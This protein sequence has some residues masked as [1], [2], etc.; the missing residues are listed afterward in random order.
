M[1]HLTDIYEEHKDHRDQFEVIAFHDGSVKD[2]KELDEK[3]KAVKDTYWGGQDLPFPILLDK[4]GQTVKTFGINHFPTTLLIDPEGKL[5]GEAGADV[6]EQKLPKVP[7]TGRLAKALDKSVSVSWEDNPLS[8]LPNFLGRSAR[9]PIKLDTA[10]LKEAG[11]DPAAKVPLKLQGAIS[12]RSALDLLLAPSG[13]TYERTDKELLIRPRKAG[14]PMPT[15][16]AGPQQRVNERIAAMLR[17]QKMAFDLK[18]KTLDEVAKYFE[19]KTRENFVLDPVARSKGRLDP[20]AKVSGAAKDVSLAEGLEQ[21]L[22]PKGL[23]AL[24]RDEV[25]VI[26]TKD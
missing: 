11:I 20:Q 3:L 13:L 26:T 19:Q 22:G 21:L 1:P 5:V 15:P 12:L 16:S 10:A 4:T 9:I 17:E 6:L 23:R 14:E 8:D 24:V 7:V 2:F 18:D 25:V